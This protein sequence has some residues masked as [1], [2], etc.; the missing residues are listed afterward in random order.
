MLIIEVHEV[1]LICA[2]DEFIV[3]QVR[4]PL[5]DGHEIGHAFFLIC[6][7]ATVL[8]AERLA[9]VG[10]RVPILP[11]DSANAISACISVD[12]ELLTEIW[13][14][15]HGCRCELQ[16]QSVKHLLRV[17]CPNKLVVFLE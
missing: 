7:K 10:D 6:G 3:V 12:H 1:S 9:H 11:K 8:G 13:K 2:D 15:Q 4:A 17:T 5:L 14:L 16:F